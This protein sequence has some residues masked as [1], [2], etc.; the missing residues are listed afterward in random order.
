[1]GFGHAVALT[2]FQ[3]I[4][5]V[6]AIINGGTFHSPA[7]AQ[8]GK[9]ATTRQVKNVI[10]PKTSKTVNELLEF[11]EN[12][13]GKYTFVEGYNVGGK[14]G[15]AQKYKESGGIDSGKYISSFIGTYPADNPQYLVFIMVDEPS[16]GAYYGS[17]VAAPYG[18]EIFTQLFVYLDEKKQDESALIE[19]ISMP[20]LIGKSLAEGASI[21]KEIGLEFE[22]DGEGE[23][24]TNQLP[25]PQT[26]IAKGTTIL[27]IAE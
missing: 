21:L 10:S 26:Q 19:Y 7:I 24:I 4:S 16:N 20:D 2:P 23:F 1:M 5:A 15:T 27:L 12:K 6:S 3:L 8:N 18:K 22:L 14:T 13:K 25:P 9:I 11:A 17:I